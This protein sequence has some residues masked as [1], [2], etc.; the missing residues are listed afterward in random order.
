MKANKAKLYTSIYW[1]THILENHSFISP[2]MIL[3][4]QK[5]TYEIK[6]GI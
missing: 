5:L 2:H 6:G 3:C 4:Y 1:Y